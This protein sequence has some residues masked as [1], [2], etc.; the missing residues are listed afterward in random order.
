MA[1]KKAGG[2]KSVGQYIRQLVKNDLLITPAIRPR[3]DNQYPVIIDEAQPSIT[4]P[5]RVNGLDH[6]QPVDFNHEG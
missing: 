5:R 1:V 6:T 4:R 3:R 2:K